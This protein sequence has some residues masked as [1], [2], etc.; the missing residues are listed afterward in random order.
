MYMGDFNPSFP[1]TISNLTGWYTGDS[2]VMSGSAMTEWTDLSG[3]NNHVTGSDLAGTIQRVSTGGGIIGGPRPFIHGGTSERMKF[4]T[5]VMTGTTNNYTLFHVTKFYLPGSTPTVYVFDDQKTGTAATGTLTGNSNNGP[6]T[7]TTSAAGGY[8]EL[9]HSGASRHGAVYWQITTG[10]SWELDAEI[11]INPINYGGADDLR[12][13]FYGTGPITGTTINATGSGGH[14]GHMLMWEYYGD[15]EVR[16]YNQTGG[17]TKSASVSLQMDAWMPVNIQYSGGTLTATIKNSGGTLLNTTTH[18]YGTSLNSNHNQPRYFGFAGRSGGVQAI[19]RVRN[20]T[21]KSMAPTLSRSRIFDGIG[22]NWLS[23]FHAG[24]TGVAYHNGWVTPSTGDLHGNDWVFSTDQ[25]SLYRSNGVTRGTGGGNLS[26]QLTVNYGPQ[27]GSQSSTWAIAEIIVYNRTLN[28]TEYTNVEN[29]LNMKYG[30]SLDLQTIGLAAGDTAPH[31]LSELYNEPFTDG[32]FTPASISAGPLSLYMFMNKTLGSVPQGGQQEYTTPG[33][34]S[35]T[36]PT[37]PAV[38][39]VCVV[40]VG[41][42]GGGMYYNRSS[43]SYS[44]SMNGGSG[45][46]LGWKNNIAVVP[47][48]SYTLVVGAG[49][50]AGAYSSGAGNGNDSYF[51]NTGTV[52]GGYGGFGRY[53][54]SRSGGTYT[55]DG[56]G[57][58]GAVNNASSSGNGP[59][60]GGGAGGYTGAGGASTNTNTSG[61]PSGGG[62][63]GGDSG[64][65]VNHSGGGGGV[66]LLGQGASGAADGF[67]GS[68]GTD[69]LFN[70]AGLYGAI[71]RTGGNYGGGGGG[72]SS[73]SWG[74]AG[75]GGGGAVRIIW[76]AGR[77]FPSTNTA[78]V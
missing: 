55:G 15:D 8:I 33:T 22:T 25:R 11:Y 49:G 26:A 58:G 32:S 21:I 20:I 9:V 19:D 68:G 66:G 40:C 41:G 50:S 78:D 47:G 76:G 72:A 63:G 29:Y 51:I 64:S 57:N 10:D 34:Y 36:A 17:T 59:C 2:A 6:A 35:W 75:A 28:S 43:T 27:Q 56:G 45:G 42:G 5:S 4:S 73:S 18:A 48:N 39:S 53:N 65:S 54:Q 61:A 37:S 69:G 38:T 52:K 62:G 30:A 67:G 71:L 70:Y 23:G 74:G 16:L 3:N 12:F 7:R 31:S 24:D 14:G 46:G 44:Y 1:S 77:A 60:G 13:I